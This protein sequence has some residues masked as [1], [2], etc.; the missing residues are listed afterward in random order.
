M[1]KSGY[2]SYVPFILLDNSWDSILI[3]FSDI[4]YLHNV[5][6]RKVKDVI[7]ICSTY[8]KTLDNIHIYS[9]RSK[10]ANSTLK[11]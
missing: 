9:S 5:S 4:D 10:W 7:K 6:E 2:I 11:P 3:L 8:L 1:D